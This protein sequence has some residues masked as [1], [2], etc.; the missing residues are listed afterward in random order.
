MGK[1]REEET[2]A[3]KLKGIAVYKAAAN[4]RRPFPAA[5]SLNHSWRIDLKG[6]GFIKTVT[7]YTYRLPGGGGGGR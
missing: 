5:Q 2:P 1:N 6:L 4:G 7:A 3:V